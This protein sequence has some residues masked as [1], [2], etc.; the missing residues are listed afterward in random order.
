MPAV[1]APVHKLSIQ[2]SWRLFKF[3]VG[4]NYSMRPCLK[5]W[6]ICMLRE[7]MGELGFRETKRRLQSTVECL[8]ECQPEFS[9]WD[10]SDTYPKCGDT[11]GFPI[12]FNWLQLLRVVFPS[13][14]CATWCRQ[15]WG[16]YQD[17][18]TFI[19]RS[20]QTHLE[21][22]GPGQELALVGVSPPRREVSC[23]L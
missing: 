14:L 9:E 16:D 13:L 6:D 18:I 4:L 10:F 1:V 11:L 5:K 2:E 20:E 22:L 19:A 7:K 23:W 17:R 21:T 3:R 15:R 12:S 8:R